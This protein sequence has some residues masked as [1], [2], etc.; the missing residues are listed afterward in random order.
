M[1]RANDAIIAAS[2]IKH[3]FGWLEPPRSLGQIAVA[4]VARAKALAE[5]RRTVRTWAASA[6]SA[7]SLHHEVIR[8]WVSLLEVVQKVHTRGHEPCARIFVSDGPESSLIAGTPP[9]PRSASRIGS[10][11]LSQGRRTVSLGRGNPWT[12]LCT[13]WR[14]DDASSQRDEYRPC[15][16]HDVRRGKPG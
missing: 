1:A 15:P 14:V 5:L 9:T 6:W 10:D 12:K 8:S 16:P 4:D 13:R 11:T 7:W 2:K 3:T